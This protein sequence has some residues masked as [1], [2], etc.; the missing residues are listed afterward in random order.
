MNHRGLSWPSALV[1]RRLS[2]AGIRFL[3]I[4]F[5]PRDSASLAVGLPALTHRT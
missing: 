4:L 1:S 2:A 3:G 5:P